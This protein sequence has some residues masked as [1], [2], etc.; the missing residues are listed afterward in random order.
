MDYSALINKMDPINPTTLAS[1]IM[2]AMHTAEQ[3]IKSGDKA[4][5]AQQIILRQVAESD[6]NDE[7]RQLCRSIADTG[8]L[9]DIFGLVVDASKGKLDVNSVSKRTAK[10]CKRWFAPFCMKFLKKQ[11]EQ[12]ENEQAIVGEQEEQISGQLELREVTDPDDETRVVEPS[13]PIIIE[14]EVSAAGAA[15]TSKSSLADSQGEV[16]FANE[17]AAASPEPV[18]PD[19]PAPSPE[20]A[21]E[22]ETVAAGSAPASSIV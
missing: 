21:N 1:H 6:M 4:E 16:F 5:F 3:C 10:C 7:E 14:T 15:S 20:E 8:I 13:S 12:D 11:K 18:V 9:K 19:A 22:A 2:T 17:D